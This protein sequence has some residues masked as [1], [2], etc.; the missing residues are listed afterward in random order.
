[1]GERF[2]RRNIENK[3]LYFLRTTKYF[4]LIGKLED[5]HETPTLTVVLIKTLKRH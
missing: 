3:Q 1:M 2:L 5:K 4:K